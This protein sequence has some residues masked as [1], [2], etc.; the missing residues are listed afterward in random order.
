MKLVLGKLLTIPAKTPIITYKKLQKSLRSP[1]YNFSYTLGRPYQN[2]RFDDN[3]TATSTSRFYSFI[4]KYAKEHEYLGDIRVFQCEV[5]GKVILELNGQIGSE[6]IKIVKELPLKEHIPLMTSG[7]AYAYCSH[8]SDL[9]S[10]RERII[11]DK[12]ILN[13]CNIIH[14]DPVLAKKIKD[15][16]YLGWYNTDKK[17]RKKN[18]EE[19]PNV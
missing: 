8:V 7:E 13:Y 2:K 11:E 10:V 4:L 19:Q 18:K 9:A 17:N 5:W 12:W 14:D 16:K 3:E 6:F 15:P 1:I